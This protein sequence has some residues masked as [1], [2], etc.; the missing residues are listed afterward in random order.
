M[1]KNR[2]KIINHIGERSDSGRHKL[3]RKN[4]LEAKF[5]RL[6]LLDPEQFNP[7]RN[8]MQRE[9]L[10]RT[11]NLLTQSVQLQDKII[12]DLGCGSGVF[13]RRM[14]DGGGVIEA[15]DIAENALKHFANDDRHHIEIKRDA[16]PET[17][18]PDEN[19]DIVSRHG[20]N[21]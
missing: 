12:V 17:K 3:S 15:V 20:V 4:E 18:L 11:W 19:Y 9:R 6:W 8:C 10:D 5:E 16:M 1:S 21:R 14:R 2:L 13:S 7:L